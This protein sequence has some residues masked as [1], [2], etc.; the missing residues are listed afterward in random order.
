MDEATVSVIKESYSRLK[1]LKLVEQ[2]TGV[3]WQTVYWHLKK[4][5]VQVVGDKARYGSA[6]HRLGVLGE[7]LFQRLVPNAVDN[8]HLKWQGSADF[9]VN[10]SSVDVKA[11][12]LCPAGKTPAGKSCSA[13][14]S[15]CNITQRDIADF[16]V[17]IALPDQGDDVEHIFLLPRELAASNTTIS[18]PLTLKS[19]WADYL[20]SSEELSQFFSSD[21]QQ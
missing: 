3:K 7:Q 6:T 2:E 17:L 18:I 20:V 21:S 10:G 15:Y 12:R 8:K 13:R 19:K 9:S 4:E 5:G 14:W 11:A 1:N 16:F